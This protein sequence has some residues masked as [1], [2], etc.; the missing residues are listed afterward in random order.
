MQLPQYPTA[1]KIRTTV[2]K[3]VILKQNYFNFQGHTYTQQEALAMGAPISAILSEVFLQCIE[4]MLIYDILKQNNIQGYFRYF[5]DCLIIYDT[6]LTDI[7]SVLNEF[8]M[9]T[10]NLKFTIEEEKDKCINFLN[11]TVIRKQQQFSFNIYLKPTVTDHIITQD[12]CH[13]QEHK[14]S[15]IRYLYNR[16]EI[17]KSNI[18]T[19]GKKTKSLTTSCVTTNTTNHNLTDQNTQ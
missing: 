5:D 16:M 18:T 14:F 6:E 7:H 10:P 17:I 19:N 1:T 4:H 11:I 15:A 12:S 2:P 13:P 8:N 9:I 3:K